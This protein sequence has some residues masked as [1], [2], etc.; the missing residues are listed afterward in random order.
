MRR[1][2]TAVSIILACFI[3]LLTAAAIALIVRLLQSPRQADEPA[4][5]QVA[6]LFTP[7]AQP[8]QGPAPTL[9]PT[10]ES[11][12]FLP[13]VAKQDEHAPE[14]Y[15][16]DAAFLGNS[17]VSGL[18]F[19]DTNGDL[20]GADFYA[21]NSMTV[22]NAES[23]VNEMSGRA[24]GKIYI[25]LGL[26]EV[27]YN[28]DIVREGFESLVRRLKEDHPGVIIYL[29]AVTPVSESKSEDDSGFTHD[30]VESFNRMLYEVAQENHVYYLDEFSVLSDDRGYLPPDVTSDGIHFSPAHYGLWF[31]YLTTH[32]I[33]AAG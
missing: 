19:Y 15:F 21:E 2:N 17:V 5:T 18:D 24:Y 11:T 1:R 9:V 16:S 29:M 8:D 25:G 13:D 33:P 22:L 28:R 27:D 20:E 30:H 31:E 3:L 26:N 10:P 7:T 32:Y 14:G 12:P 23:Y 4:A 6:A